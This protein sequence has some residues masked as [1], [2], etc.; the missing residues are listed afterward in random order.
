MGPKFIIL[1]IIAG[2]AGIALGTWVCI[3]VINGV[4]ERIK[5]V[6]QRKANRIERERRNLERY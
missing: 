3:I 6:N 1:Y 4:R 2:L 5:N